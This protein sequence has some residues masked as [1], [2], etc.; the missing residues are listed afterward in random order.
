MA[1]TIR[2]DALQDTGANDIITSDGSGTFTYNGIAASAIDSGT[3][4]TARLGSGTADATT[5]LRG[6]QT[7]AAGVTGSVA[8]LAKMS[9][10]QTAVNNTLTKVEFDTQVYDVGGVYDPA[11]YRFTCATAGKYSIYTTMYLD[12]AASASLQD[13]GVNIYKNGARDVQTLINCDGNRIQ[14]ESQTIAYMVDL[15]V[16]DYIEVYAYVSQSG[17]TATLRGSSDYAVFGGWLVV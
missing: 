16:S 12:G 9:G 5:F 14:A 13:G 1:S 7:Y 2:V 15:S 6:D 17:G 10:D 4:A 11:A 3:M 8:F